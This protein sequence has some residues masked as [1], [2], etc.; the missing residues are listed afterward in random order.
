[1][2]ELGRAPATAHAPA[3]TRGNGA[4]RARG[5][6]NWL[7]ASSRGGPPVARRGAA[8]LIGVRPAQTPPRGSEAPA[9]FCTMAPGGRTAS[10]RAGP[11]AG[12]CAQ[13]RGAGADKAG[14]ERLTHTPP[15][16]RLDFE[17]LVFR[18]RRWTVWG[19]HS[20][21]HTMGSPH[22]LGSPPPSRSPHPMGSPNPI[23]S[24]QPMEPPHVLGSPHPM[25]PPTPMSSPHA[26]FSL[27]PTMSAQPM[28]STPLR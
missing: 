5:D 6:L 17:R 13:G 4:G 16:L 28:G 24:L 3:R 27:K 1:M 8:R 23:V 19:R 26:V 12:S 25:A 21:P 15:Q 2:H 10:L 11:V 20:L 14:D 18:K 22:P 9:T 7:S